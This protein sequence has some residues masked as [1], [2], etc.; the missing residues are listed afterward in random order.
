MT[1][2]MKSSKTAKVVHIVD[3]ENYVTACGMTPTD[4][5]VDAPTYSQTEDKPCEKCREAFETEIKQ[6]TVEQHLKYARRDIVRQ[7]DVAMTDASLTLR[8][9]KNRLQGF[10]MLFDH[11]AEVYVSGYWKQAYDLDAQRFF[12]DDSDLD[13]LSVFRVESLQNK[14]FTTTLMSGRRVQL[15]GDGIKTI[16]ITQPQR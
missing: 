16:Y 3:D 9:L 2:Y 8:N 11:P 13:V 4:R 5:W 1:T 12:E 10:E 14:Y 15:H 6:A 7:Y